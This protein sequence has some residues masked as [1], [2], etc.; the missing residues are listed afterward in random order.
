MA[1][2]QK[3]PRCDFFRYQEILNYNTNNNNKNLCQEEKQNKTK[4]QN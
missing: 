2:G 3:A 1:Y 4:K